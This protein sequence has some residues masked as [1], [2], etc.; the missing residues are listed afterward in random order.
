MTESEFY[1]FVVP[2]AQGND[3]K[4]SDYKGK[5]V[6]VVNVASSCGKTP[7][8]AGLQK[9]YEKYKDQGL[10]ILAFPCNQFAFQERGSNEEICTFTRDKYKVT[11]KMFAKTTVNGGDTIPLYQYL[12]KEGE[13]SLFNA[14]K[15]NFTKFLVSKSGKVLQRYSP[16][17]EPED[18]EEDIKKLLAE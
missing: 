7:Q 6:M 9:L 13:G 1:S 15:W 17:T 12:K 16:N 3:V 14:I 5:V 11:F 4:L 8:Y 18:M 10:E 2:D